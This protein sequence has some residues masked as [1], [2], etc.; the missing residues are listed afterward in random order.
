MTND[1][2]ALFADWFKL[3]EA[4]EPSDAN[5]MTLATARDGQPSARIVLLKAFDDRGFVF[6]TNL[7]SRK[8]REIAANPAAALLFHWKSLA[9]QIRIEGRL[10][11]VSDA[12]ADAYFATRPR[13]SQI[14]AWAS[15]QSEA[16]PGG[17]AEFEAALEVVERRFAG[18]DV[19]RPPHWSGY[20][21][22][23]ERIE[24]W[25]GR[26]YRLHERRLFVRSGN[27]WTTE[28]LYP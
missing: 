17:R 6:Y 21:L 23:P 28:W 25:E 11:R 14:G 15:R 13:M 7:E 1:P 8:G 10:A 18:V 22:A 16:M 12:E 5:A 26:D 9:R 2:F 4:K 20:R 3:A 19:P 27:G 24:F